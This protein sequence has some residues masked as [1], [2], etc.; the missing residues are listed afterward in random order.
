MF[1]STLAAAAAS[2]L[3]APKPTNLR[4][5]FS[6]NDVPPYLYQKDGFWDVGVRLVVAADGSLRGCIVQMSSGISDLDKLTCDLIRQRGRFQA[7]QWI[8][9]S[10]VTGVYSTAVTYRTASWPFDDRLKPPKGDFS[11]L[12][13]T[14]DQLPSGRKSPSLVRAKFAVDTSGSVSSCGAEVTEN[15]I[16]AENDPALVPVACDQILKAFKP[17]SFKDSS[18]NP[19]RSVQDA[20]V[21]FVKP[22]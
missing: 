3:S 21:R 15:F 11:D 17:L 19:V 7:A 9:G 8:D 10:P 14:V 12:D 20:L 1:W 5:W 6:G 16:S 13:V 22:Q 4:D 18:G 2:Q